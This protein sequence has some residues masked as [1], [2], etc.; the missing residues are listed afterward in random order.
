M[1]KGNF[2]K[3]LVNNKWRNSDFYY[4]FVAKEV[5]S[6]DVDNIENNSILMYKRTSRDD[7]SAIAA[8]YK[9]Q[10]LD[11]KI[12]L[13]FEEIKGFVEF[14]DHGFRIHQENGQILELSQYITY[15]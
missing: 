5:I 8:L 13:F 3:W 11:G 10:E 2:I 14:F 7:G 1:E 6:E 12:I 15:Y 4:D 9:V